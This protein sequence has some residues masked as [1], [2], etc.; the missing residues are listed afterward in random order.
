MED[1]LIILGADKVASD[2]AAADKAA[3]ER[4]ADDKTVYEK[5]ATESTAGESI[6]AI[7]SVY[8]KAGAELADNN[9][10]CESVGE[11]IDAAEKLTNMEDVM[12]GMVYKSLCFPESITKGLIGI[13]GTNVSETNKVFEIT[14]NITIKL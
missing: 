13:C 3:A 7:K 10:D 11:A 9:T 2:K 5:A 6:A 4:L 12:D 14:S 1:S 8:E